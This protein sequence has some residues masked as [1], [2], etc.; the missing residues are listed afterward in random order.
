MHE[1]IDADSTTE[2]VLYATAGGV[3]AVGTLL[4]SSFFAG[5]KKPKHINEAGFEYDSEDYAD[6][7]FRW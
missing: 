6:E 5:C 1:A 2:T 7:C 3:Q 4:A